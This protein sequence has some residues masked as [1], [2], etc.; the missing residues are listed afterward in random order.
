[1]PAPVAVWAQ[2]PSAPIATIAPVPVPETSW[3]S[4]WE[5]VAAT[6]SSPAAPVALHTLQPPPVLPSFP[7]PVAALLTA[8]DLPL[9]VE[10]RV[11]ET[12]LA[13]Q[14]VAFLQG[15]APQPPRP[16][17]PPAQAPRRSTVRLGFTDAS[18]VDLR[19]DDPIA[20]A[21]HTV[22]DALIGRS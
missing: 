11:A 15:V 3:T 18:V 12:P 14:A 19:P 5:A 9:P 7:P 20:K 1:M 10:I 8:L 13:A 2:A 22:A 4:E 6:P 21:L 16:P 17:L